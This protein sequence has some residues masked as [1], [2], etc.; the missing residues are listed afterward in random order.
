MTVITINWNSSLSQL[1]NWQISLQ[2]P[3][4]AVF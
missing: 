1:D 2:S 3:I 4:K